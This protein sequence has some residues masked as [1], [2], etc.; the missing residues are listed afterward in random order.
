M[1]LFDLADV[2]YIDTSGLGF[3]SARTQLCETKEENTFGFR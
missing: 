3:R 2:S 1:I